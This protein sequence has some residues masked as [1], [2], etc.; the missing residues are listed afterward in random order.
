MES[1]WVKLKFNVEEIELLIYFIQ[2]GLFIF[3]VWI[4]VFVFGFGIFVVVFGS[5]FFVVSFFF[6][7]V[8]K[9]LKEIDD[10]YNRCIMVVLKRMNIFFEDKCGLNIRKMIEK[11]MKEF[12]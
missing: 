4:V 11:V 8:M 12:F 3:L 10:E 6:N 9:I 7:W 2:F 1:E 5:I